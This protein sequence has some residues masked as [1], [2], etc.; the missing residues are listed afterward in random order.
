MT[1]VNTC[2]RYRSVGYF[3][4]SADFAQASSPIK[5]RFHGEEGDWQ[6]TPFQVADCGHDR[7][8]CEAMLARYF[9]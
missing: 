3:E 8:R 2:R 9:R 5:I 4:Y 7:H 1:E 6:S